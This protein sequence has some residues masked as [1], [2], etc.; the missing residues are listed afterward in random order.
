MPSY[1]KADFIMAS[2][3][4]DVGDKLNLLKR[5]TADVQEL[6]SDH[7]S[8]LATL[9]RK[10]L[11]SVSHQF[12][13]N[14]DE[15][16]VTTTVSGDALPWT[17]RF[18]WDE[19][20]DEFSPL[21]DIE[22]S[23]P[24]SGNYELCK[25]TWAVTSILLRQLYTDSSPLVRALKGLD[26]DAWKQVLTP[27]DRFLNATKEAATDSGAN[28]SDN[29]KIRRL[30]YRIE[31]ERSELVVNVLEQGVLKS[32]D[33]GKG[34]KM[35]WTRMAGESLADL[36]P[37]DQQV[38]ALV[39]KNSPSREYSPFNAYNYRTPERAPSIWELLKILTGHPL[40]FCVKEPTTP[41][42]ITKSEI[43]LVL[44]N[45]PDGRLAMLP[46]MGGRLLSTLRDVVFDPQHGIICPDWKNN[47]LHYWEGS[48]AAVNLIQQL[49]KQQMTIPREGLPELLGRLT[50]LERSFKVIYPKEIQGQT[51]AG[52]SQT[53]LRLTPRAADG[54]LAVEIW[55]RPVVNGPYYEPG[56]GV[57]T[58]ASY[59]DD[60]RIAIERD[61]PA[62]LASAKHC[63]E[64]LRLDRFHSLRPWRWMLEGGDN[65]FDFL[66][67]LQERTDAPWTVEWSNSAIPRPDM[68][69]EITPSNLLLE[70]GGDHDWFGVE[71][72]I[73]IGGER[74]PLMAIL[75]ALRK[76]SRYVQLKGGK[77]AKIAA[78]FRDRLS[79]LDDLLH[80]NHSKMNLDATAAPL[81][82]DLFKDQQINIKAATEWR[83]A[84]QRLE[85]ARNH[86]PEV[87]ADL[88]ADLRDYQVDGYR[89]L[90]RLAAWGVGGCLA[91]DMG[92][93][94]TVQALAV[95][96]ERQKVGPTLV[97]A[98][99]SVGFNWVKETMRFAPT[100]RPHLYRDTERGEFLDSVGPGDLVVASYGL[101]LR[102]IE[103][104]T[105]IR[106][107]TLVLD[108]AQFIKN[109][110][111]KSAQA[112]REINAE[113]RLTLT[114]T[115]VENQLG[116]LWSLF[117]A[118]SPGLFGSWERFRERFADPIEKQKIPER[119]QALSRT[120]R[121]FILR[122]TKDEV[123]KELPARTEM[124]LTAELSKPER[125]L[126]ED[127]RL[128]ALAQLSGIDTG[129]N[130]SR[131]QVLAMLTRLRQLACH[132]KLVDEN[133]K[134]SSAKLDVLLETVEEIREGKHR[135]LIFSQFTSHLEIIRKA[136]DERNVSYLYL[137]GQ[138]PE[139][140]R[141]ERVED[142]Q[143]GKGDL[144]L[145]SLKAGGTGLNLTGADYVIHMDPWWNPA[146]EDQA[147]DRAHRIG[148]TKPVMV[149]RLVAQD[150]IEEKILAMHEKKRH[151]VADIMS[152]SDQAG[153]LSTDDLIELIK[154]SHKPEMPAEKK[155]S[156]KRA[157]RAKPK[158]K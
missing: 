141:R 144:F 38:I 101:L 19:F 60:E 18:I 6:L 67:D 150:T 131:F 69:G 56:E 36:G 108:E 112:V 106:W 70:I 40:V 81:L 43:E 72:T 31:V 2:S 66:S 132:P 95:L 158:D 50:Q 104:F 1:G 138:T 124:I 29:T 154:A 25:H 53:Y 153:K 77:W 115:P 37:I 39:K 41:L 129:K 117:R 88:K 57:T 123:L 48:S 24:T 3:R 122:R 147:T 9:G 16:V 46:R 134:E 5:I 47:Q 75:D 52:D 94:K 125:K 157:A 15:C 4:R 111:T 45:Q 74:I 11:A 93:G 102:D 87:P 71:G 27:L 26:P 151:L 42:A 103:Y 97:V 137:D 98:P 14:L 10:Y 63:Q 91:D 96:L 59:K 133:W 156:P 116:D 8:H 155:K 34:S 89:W 17:V 49:N 136:L 149:Y 105:K 7:G 64:T 142:F 12:Q 32:G 114:G 80:R 119:S 28:P 145:I 135:A 84:L 35:T 83:A 110:R 118:T 92:L 44:K 107:G 127:A 99:V 152:G 55:A 78:E 120:I 113:W 68:V 22:C 76:N 128:F 146:V 130:E 20:A 86:N 65:A 13:V 23:C 58:L 109:S 121:P 73:E 30:V 100:L 21:T 82:E 54:G 148:Q 62:E 140:Q 139:K 79:A 143:N 90:S 51:V 126:Y 85:N 61:L 33:W